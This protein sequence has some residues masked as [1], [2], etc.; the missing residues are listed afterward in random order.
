MI[1]PGYELI[2]IG[3]NRFVRS[4]NSRGWIYEGA[5]P[6]AKGHAMYD[7]IERE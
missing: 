7:R 3:T 2:Q 1:E 4:P 5:L 6:I